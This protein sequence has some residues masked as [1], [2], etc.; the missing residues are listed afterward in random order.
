MACEIDTITTNF[1]MLGAAFST[2]KIPV[3][4]ETFKQTIRDSFAPKIAQMNIKAFERG[5]DECDRKS[6]GGS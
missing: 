5:Y 2:G 4:T 1:V 6:G 3:S